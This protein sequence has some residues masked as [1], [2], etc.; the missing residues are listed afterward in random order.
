MDGRLPEDGF[1]GVEATGEEGRRTLVDPP[2]TGLAFRLKKG[3]YRFKSHEEADEWWEKVK[4]TAFPL[5][6]QGGDRR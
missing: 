5:Q 2:G 6:P 3:V 1:N 4:T